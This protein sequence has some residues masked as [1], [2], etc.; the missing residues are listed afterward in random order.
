MSKTLAAPTSKNKR[1]TKISDFENI[2]EA[3]D[4][5]QNHEPNEK[6]K[7]CLATGVFKFN[8]GIAVNNKQ[9]KILVHRCKTSINTS[10]KGL[11]Y[12]IINCSSNECHELLDAIPF[13]AT[14]QHE[15]RQWTIRYKAQSNEINQAKKKSPDTS[16][17]FY[18]PAAPNIE[19]TQQTISQETYANECDD[20]FNDCDPFFF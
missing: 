16:D 5:F 7:R 19:E 6:W 15:L 13:L 10:L 14:N 3:I 4:I 9:L 17:T 11:G 2:L 18:T 1:N 8:G 20:F 12:T